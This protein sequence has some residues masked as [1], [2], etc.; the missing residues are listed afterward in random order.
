MLISVIVPVYNVEKYLKE[1]LDSIISQVLNCKRGAEIILVDDGSTDSSG[2]ICDAYKKEYPGIITVVH[3]ENQGLLLARRTGLTHAKGEYIISCDSDDKL[4]GCAIEEISRVIDEY[5]PDVII[6]NADR[7]RGQECTPIYADVFSTSQVSKVSK[8]AV[9]REYLW[10]RVPAVTVS[11]WGKAVKKSCFDLEK[12]YSSFGKSSMGEDTLQSAEIYQK[13]KS[14]VYLN[15]SLYD[16][17]SGSGM[18]SRFDENYFDSFKKIFEYVSAYGYIKDSEEYQFL[19]GAK[20]LTTAG[21][22][23]TQSCHAKMSSKQRTQFVKKIVEDESI[24]TLLADLKCYKKFLKPVHFALL[25]LCKL[26]LYPVVNL[27]LIGRR[28]VQRGKRS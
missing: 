9:V 5:A 18:T 19:L 14:F 28:A 8:E 12:D 2:R 1:C 6:Y 16:Y 24:C 11:M 27:A 23:I 4:K 3:K 25:S 7:L 20:R 10:D 26:R 22:A 13:A 15:E 21:R 17:R